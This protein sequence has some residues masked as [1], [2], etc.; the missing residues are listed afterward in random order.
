MDTLKGALVVLASAF[1]AL[2]VINGI[3]KAFEILLE[4]VTKLELWF[5]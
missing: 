1:V 4:Q 5:Q 2:K 3:I